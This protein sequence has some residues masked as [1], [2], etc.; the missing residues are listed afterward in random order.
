MKRL[1]MMLG[2]A[3]TMAGRA[4]AFTLSGTVTRSIGGVVYP[5]DIDVRDRDTGVLIPTPGD[6]TLA[7][8]A[9]VLTLPNG[10]YRVAFV[11]PVAASLMP[12][13]FPDVRIN[14][15]DLTL[16][17]SLGPAH[18]VSGRVVDGGGA[19]VDVVNLNFHDA[20]GNTPNNVF[21]D[22]SNANGDF[23]TAVDP[24]VWDIDFIP[25]TASRRVPI[26][27]PGVNLASGNVNLGTL[28]V[29]A[30]WIITATVT[31]GGFFPLTAADLDVKPSAGG[32]K[33]FTP[34]DNTDAS[35]TAVMV[36][37]PGSYDVIGNPPDGFPYATRTARNVA[38]A[39]DLTVPNLALPPGFAL[40]ATCR[41]PA[42]APLAGVDLDVDSLPLIRRLETA[43][44]ASNASGAINTLVSNWKFRITLSPPVSTRFL[45]VRFDS[46]QMNN[47][48]LNLGTITF[49]QGHWV[50]VNVVAAGSQT[51]IAGANLDF[52]RTSNGALAITPG[53]VTNAGGQAVVVTDTDLYTLRVV[54]PNATYATVDLTGFRSLADTVITVALPLQ[55]TAVPESGRARGLA[56]ASPWPNP[57]RGQT[58]S[59]VATIESGSAD[60]E[61][62]DL[63]GRRIASIARGLV[64]GRHALRWNGRDDEGR[65]PG[66]GIYY[67]RLISRETGSATARRIAVLN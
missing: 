23:V 41:T 6:T 11:P 44:D 9:Y 30:G 58:I 37:P 54:S 25:P 1:I 52:I 64:A 8:G 21:S 12:I 46:V 60:L 20:V 47:A 53:D 4:D 49:A 22:K 17:A 48:P 16:N 39:G 42:S 59:L 29:Q 66:S 32:P 28:T 35:G 7:N 2:L 51:P 62:V 15:S 57:A 34:T 38:V 43:N 5:C 19:P 13:E 56:L 31:D 36:V 10:R 50:T 3:L 67:V 65:Q 27:V 18:W 55:S 26:L 24:G 33:L 63:A 45:P 40:S 61:I 14:N